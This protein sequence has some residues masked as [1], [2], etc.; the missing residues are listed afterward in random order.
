MKAKGKKMFWG[1]TAFKKH[2][3]LNRVIWGKKRKNNPN[4]NQKTRENK[5][6]PSKQKASSL[7]SQFITWVRS[8]SIGTKKE[9]WLEDFCY[10]FSVFVNNWNFF[11]YENQ[12]MASKYFSIRRW[13]YFYIIDL[14][15]NCVRSY[16]LVYSTT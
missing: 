15:S 13:F 10:F 14:L 11:H 2:R 9:R 7:K 1:D 3:R 16:L 6:T 8:V 4:E 5:L 12:E